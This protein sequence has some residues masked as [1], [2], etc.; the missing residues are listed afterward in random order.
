MI[1]EINPDIRVIRND[2]M[3]VE[4]IRALAPDQ[5]ILSPG[6]G[7]PEDA[8][9][10]HRSGEDWDRRH[11]DPGRLPGTSG[12]L[13]GIWGNDY[14]RKEADARK[15]VRGQSLTRTARCFGLPGDA[16]VARYHSL[17]ADP[18]T[19]PDEL[20]V[21]ARDGGRRGHGGSAQGV[22]HLRGTVSSG[23]HPDTGRK[24]DVGEFPRHNRGGEG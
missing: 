17:A 15:A 11:P 22:S 1:G 2:E 23:I 12:D 19:L 8:G 7:R 20:K 16:P 13:R 9:R 4:E 6:P 21:T 3:T 10:H 18:D 24:K 5:I 14:L